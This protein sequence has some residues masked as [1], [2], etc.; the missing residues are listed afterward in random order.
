M[1]SRLKQF[2]GPLILVLG[3]VVLIV[4]ASQVSP[5]RSTDTDQLSS[6]PP[7]VQDR[8]TPSY[9]G[10][11]QPPVVSA[12]AATLTDGDEVIGVVIGGK[13]RAY[14]LR[15]LGGAPQNHVV[16]DVMADTP[17]S[18]TYCDLGRCIR[19]YT[20]SGAEPLDI[21]AAGLRRDELMLKVGGRLFSQKTGDTFDPGRS[22][23]FPFEAVAFEKTTWKK[24]RA[25]HP[26]TEVS[27]LSMPD[28]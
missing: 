26:D 1:S 7:Q 22:D 4:V 11:K 2:R 23:R 19:V 12:A 14:P 18:V 3:G 28:R 21:H 6:A 8:P 13:A 17:V 27:A 9:P 25:A 16:N 5:D 10:V 20:H 24:W 15:A